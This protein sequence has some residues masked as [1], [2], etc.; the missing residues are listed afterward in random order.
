MPANPKRVLQSERS[1][2]SVQLDGV[3]ASQKEESAVKR[4]SDL[5]TQ[6]KNMFLLLISQCSWVMAFCLAENHNELSRRLTRLNVRPVS[7]TTLD[8]AEVRKFQAMASKWWDLQGA[9][10][11]LHSMNDLRVPLIRCVHRT[12]KVPWYH[13][14]IFFNISQMFGY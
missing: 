10:T 3:S 4:V 8:P 9:F 12:K 5:S 7:Q 14:S 13:Y 2:V 11:A 1:A 6:I